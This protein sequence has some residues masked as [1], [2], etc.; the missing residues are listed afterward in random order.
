[1]LKDIVSVHRS[2]MKELSLSHAMSP[3][4]AVASHM[5]SYLIASLGDGSETRMIS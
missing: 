4:K 1:M 2:T 3:V 5:Y